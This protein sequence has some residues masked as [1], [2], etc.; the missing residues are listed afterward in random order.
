MAPTVA[1][2]QNQMQAIAC[3]LRDARGRAAGAE[4]LMPTASW[5]GDRREVA[6]QLVGVGLAD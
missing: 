5:R 1:Q 6:A 4:L 3:V 2:T